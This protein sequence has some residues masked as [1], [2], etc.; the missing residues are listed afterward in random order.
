[1]YQNYS[2]TDK[3]EIID[4]RF[5]LILLP[6][7]LLALDPQASQSVLSVSIQNLH[8][9]GNLLLCLLIPSSHEWIPFT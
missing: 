9:V 8:R 1:M 5:C 2:F 7:R 3:L 6:F 4:H